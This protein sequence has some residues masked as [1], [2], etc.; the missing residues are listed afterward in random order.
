MAL[1]PP[2][3]LKPADHPETWAEYCRRR[4]IT[5]LW[6]RIG[7]FVTDGQLSEFLFAPYRGVPFFSDQP[8]RPR[9]FATLAD[10]LTP[11]LPPIGDVL[12][13]ALAADR[14]VPG[15]RGAGTAGPRRAPWEAQSWRDPK[16]E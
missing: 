1:P 6:R 10:C 3:P 15:A 2:I 12:A 13:P 4:E 14:P 9:R 16:T 8:L 7:D 11:A 5:A